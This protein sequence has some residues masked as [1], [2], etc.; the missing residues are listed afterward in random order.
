MLNLFIFFFEN[1][2]VF[3]SRGNIK[4]GRFIHLDCVFQ[5]FSLHPEKAEP[6]SRFFKSLLE[7]CP[8]GA[9]PSP[10]LLPMNLTF[11][12]FPGLVPENQIPPEVPPHA[13]FA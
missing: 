11:L 4:E 5:K 8:V 3:H 1:K 2:N 6:Q 12:G 7:Y 13:R 9:N 10:P